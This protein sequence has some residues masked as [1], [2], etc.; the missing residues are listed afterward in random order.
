MTCY[1]YVSVNYELS[2]ARTSINNPKARSTGNPEQNKRSKI[3]VGLH[4]AH[5]I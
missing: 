1:A 4:L 5:H 3:A 2:D